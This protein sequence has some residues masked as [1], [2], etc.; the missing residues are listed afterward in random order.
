MTP[1]KE[2]VEYKLNSITLPHYE[3][4]SIFEFFNDGR[5]TFR[6]ENGED[7][8]PL[9]RWRINHDIKRIEWCCE[10]TPNWQTK[11]WDHD[12]NDYR[13]YLT[14]KAWMDFNEEVEKTLIAIE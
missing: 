11:F 8:Q 10:D 13:L 3:E 7:M 6:D 5:Y 12:M 9:S 1:F 2:E 14:I 4:T